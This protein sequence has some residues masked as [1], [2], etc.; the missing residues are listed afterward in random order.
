VPAMCLLWCVR[1]IFIVSLILMAG[2]TV[3]IRVW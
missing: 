1:P 3:G 2:A